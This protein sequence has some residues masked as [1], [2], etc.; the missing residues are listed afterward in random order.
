MCGYPIDG[1]DNTR[2]LALTG[3]VQDASRM[4]QCVLRDAVCCPD[5]GSGDVRAVAITITLTVVY[6]V[7]DNRCPSAEFLVGCTD[8]GVND[9]NVSTCSGL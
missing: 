3:T 5:R 7:E 9:I 2:Y 6:R 8:P 1:G 4:D